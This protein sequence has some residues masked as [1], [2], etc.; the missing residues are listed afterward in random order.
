MKPGEMARQG[1]VGK[2]YA[3]RRRADGGLG[4]LAFQEILVSH[5][6]AMHRVSMTH[7]TSR[8]GKVARHSM[9]AM[10]GFRRHKAA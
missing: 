1:V 2:A 3:G 5:C 10:S 6:T 8:G 9:S 7:C 4:L